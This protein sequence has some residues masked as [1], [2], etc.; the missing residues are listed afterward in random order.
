MMIS[1]DIKFI[2]NSR[3]RV[4]RSENQICRNCKGEGEY[5]SGD[6]HEMTE[7]KVCKGSG[8]VKVTKL[9]FIKVE[10]I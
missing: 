4:E 10:A 8:K 1:E 7:C 3:A 2:E 9:I 5:L 6:G